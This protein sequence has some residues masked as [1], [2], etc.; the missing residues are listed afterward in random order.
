METIPP[1]LII[2]I[3]ILVILP[4]CI[5]IYLRWQLYQNLIDLEKQVR[6]LIDLNTAGNKPRIIEKLETRF[7][8][9]SRNLEQVNTGALINQIYSQEKL[10][11]IT[12]D[13]IEYLCRLLPN[14]LLAFGLLGTFLGITINLSS[15]S[16]AL[17]QT[18]TNNISNLVQE[19]QQPLQGMSIA[20]VTSLTG[21]LFSAVITVISWVKNTS[22]AKYRLINC[23][24]DYLDNIYQPQLQGDTRLDKIVNRMVQ[25][26]D[27]FLTNFGKTV[28]EAVESSM[29]RVAQQM[30]EGNNSAT[31]LAKQVYEQFYNAA[32]TINS[33]ATRFDQ[34]MEALSK[35]SEVFA[36]AA[37]TFEKSDFPKKLSTATTQL[38]TTQ[39]KFTRSATSLAE[40]MSMLL[41]CIQELTDLGKGIKTLNETSIDVLELNQNNQQSL[42]EIIPQ[43]QQGANTLSRTLS[44]IDKLEQKITDKADSLEKVDTSLVQLLGVVRSYTEGVS[45]GIESFA[46]RINSTVCQQINSNNQKFDKLTIEFKNI[47]TKNHIESIE[48]YQE[49]GAR[50]LDK[51]TTNNLTMY[52]EVVATQIQQCIKQLQEMKQLIA[53]SK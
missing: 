40:T 15:L 28:R 13:Q 16:Q 52:Q 19:L 26:Q 46:D 31:K 47:I 18:S 43:L 49:L 9:A 27:E 37:K 5:T 35:N 50:F 36:Q 25:Q 44:K 24:E 45:L 29:G 6:R 38:S 10:G 1:Y 41:S 34:A 42:K 20:F 53:Q 3:L 14:L 4:S 2:L 51:L 22:F 23:L 11:Q 39:E 8:V 17:N 32:G 12:Y 33:A 48:N 7:E 30:I 21:L